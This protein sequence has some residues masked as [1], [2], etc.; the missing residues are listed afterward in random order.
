[1][2][3]KIFTF[4]ALL[5]MVCG[6]NA[7]NVYTTTTLW[8]DTFTDNIAIPVSS[9]AANDRI[10]VYMTWSGSEG[11]GLHVFCVTS[12]WGQEKL[13]DHDEYPW[14]GNGT[15]SY[16]FDLTSADIA[17]MESGSY[18]SYLYIGT[19]NDSRM[20]IAK[21]TKT[22]TSTEE[23]TSTTTIWSGSVAKDAW[24][25]LEDSEMNTASKNVKKG[26]VFRVTVTNASAGKVMI[27]NAS[28]WATLIE[29][30]NV[31]QDEV[32]TIELEITDAATLEKIQNHGILVRNTA[33]LTITKVELLTYASS[34]DCVP[35]TIGS[36]GI[37]TFSCS[38][39][40]DFTSTGVT[41]YS[42]SSVAT[43]I[44]TLTATN[45][46]C[47]YEYCGYILQGEAG[48]YDV[49]VTTESVD[50]PAQYLKGQVGEGTVKASESGDTKFRYIFAKNNSGDI[51]F[52]KL[53]ADH[54]LAAH[55]AYL[56]TDT[57]ITPTRAGVKALTL[58]FDDGQTTAIQHVQEQ[59]PEERAFY[60][61][62]GVRVQKPT[63]GLYI[64]NG[65]K[66][67]FK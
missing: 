7:K 27:C 1:M 36:D 62:S 3:K 57:D 61:L 28:G 51:G 43:G 30:N 10:T 37:A 11:C 26:D 49:P 9:L 63:N 19:A 5:A 16:S 56:E 52:Y 6:A 34:Y 53:T 33:A 13:N 39:H 31:A 12:S 41:P 23:A 59:Q 46:S 38:K 14:Q 35:A 67:F 20:T 21:I 64:V 24:G 29:N 60:N 55:K 65:K 66:V 40:L 18:Q 42:V 54:T 15:E 58:V 2:K 45:N 50:Y 25:T 32:Q 47:T 8:E 22:V 4:V 17:T 44:V 48:T